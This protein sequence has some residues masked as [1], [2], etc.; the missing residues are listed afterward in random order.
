MSRAAN[1]GHNPAGRGLV[2]YVFRDLVD[3]ARHPP[4][5]LVDHLEHTELAV[6]LRSIS[7]FAQRQLQESHRRRQGRTQLVT[8]YRQCV[9]ALEL[10]QCSLCAHRFRHRPRRSNIYAKRTVT[11]GGECCRYAADGRRTVNT[12]PP[13]GGELTANEP[14][15]ASTIFLAI[16]RPSPAPPLSRVRDWSAR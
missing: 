12:A 4:Q 3:H 14:R 11:S 10:Y 1:A 8:E 9:I 2:D 13:S 7:R 5:L 15:W 16:A 6:G